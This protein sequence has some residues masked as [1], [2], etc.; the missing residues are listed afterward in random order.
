MEQ[1]FLK[2][3]QL[4]LNS[5]PIVIFMLPAILVGFLIGTYPG[6][7]AYEYVW[8]NPTFCT[9]CHVHDYANQSWEESSHGVLTTC[10]DC[11]HQS[12]RMLALEPIIFMAKQ[13]KFPKDLKHIPHVPNDLCEACHV[14]APRDTSTISGPLSIKDVKKLPKVDKTRLHQVH[15]NATTRL[16]INSDHELADKNGS[17]GQNDL[18]AQHKTGVRGIVCADCHGGVSNRAHN[19][20]AV[21]SACIRCHSAIHNSSKVVKDGG[22]R[23]CHFQEFLM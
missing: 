16:S 6:Y 20:Q 5:K 17:H 12:L 9:S 4:V 22:C 19:F 3:K 2:A 10:H 13:P 1:I 15:L 21:G 18:S 14:S 8:T 23:G 11:H 7:K